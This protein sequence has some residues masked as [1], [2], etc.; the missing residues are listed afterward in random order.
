MLQHTFLAMK[1]YLDHSQDLQR[2]TAMYV[3]LS[4]AIG[5]SCLGVYQKYMVADKSYDL[6]ANY[7][8]QPLE[9]RI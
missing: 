9:A 6:P 8:E 7:V 1:N 5:I 4:F 3:M 2:K